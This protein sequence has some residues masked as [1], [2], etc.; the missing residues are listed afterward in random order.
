MS[1]T[2]Y[3]KEMGHAVEGMMADSSLRVVDSCVS[4]DSSDLSIGQMVEVDTV[5]A[6]RAAIK[7]A[8]ST[9]AAFE[10]WGVIVDSP[11]YTLDDTSGA[12][13]KI[14]EKTICNVMRK[15]RVWVKVVG[16]VVI[17]NKAAVNSSGKLTAASSA[18]SYGTTGAIDN[19]RYLTS[20]S[21][22]KLALLELF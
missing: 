22:G 17:G 7:G 11:E 13:Q 20:A 19:G 4:S 6:G 1:Q 12:R 21:S 9:T 15:G 10:M 2:T 5:K 3:N 18:S 16:A 8:T 14:K